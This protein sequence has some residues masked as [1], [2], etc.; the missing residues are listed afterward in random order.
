M[1][2]RI[3]PG[4]TAVLGAVIG[5]VTFGLAT[6]AMATGTVGVTPGQAQRGQKVT[7]HVEECAEDGS[8]AKSDAFA[9]DVILNT[10]GERVGVAGLATIA[11]HATFGV[12]QVHVE[13]AGVNFVGRVT[14]T[15]GKG[16]PAGKGHPVPKGGAKTGLGGGGENLPLVGAGSALLLGAGG[17]GAL[18]IRR[19][20]SDARS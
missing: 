17:V 6:P 14:V 20:R 16:G 19:R 11:S 5:A 13:C 18:A 12:H 1:R 7:V 4:N 8:V 2:M 10:E 15:A 3:R 9:A